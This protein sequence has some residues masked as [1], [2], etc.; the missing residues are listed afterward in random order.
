M[1]IYLACSGLW[2]LTNQMRLCFSGGGLKDTDTRTEHFRYMVV[3]LFLQCCILLWP[4]LQDN[5]NNKQRLKSIVWPWRQNILR[6]AMDEC[7]RS[8]T[9]NKLPAFPSDKAHNKASWCLPKQPSDTSSHSSPA[10]KKKKKTVLVCL[11]LFLLVLLESFLE[12]KLIKM[13]WFLEG[14]QARK[15]V[16]LSAT[17]TGPPCS[18]VS[19]SC[20]RF[21][22]NFISW[23]K[24]VTMTPNTSW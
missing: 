3:S 8:Q 19:S 5:A 4:K 1:G 2:E 7:A 16:F 18:D 23:T 24:Q 15:T 10:G 14:K 13:F 11:P 9:P 6:L 17:L 12:C 22:S 20:A 21:V